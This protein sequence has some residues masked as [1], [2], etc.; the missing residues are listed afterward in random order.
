MTARWWY[1][2]VVLLLLLRVHCQWVDDVLALAQLPAVNEPMILDTLRRR[3]S[4]GEIYTSVGE[5]LLSINPFK[6]LPIY[7][8]TAMDAY[9]TRGASSLP[10]HIFLIADHAYRGLIFDGIDQSIVISGESGSGKTEA[11]KLALSY[12]A[13]VA[14]SSTSVEQRV[15]QANP[16]LEAYGNA[17]TIRNNNSSRFGK[18]VE[19]SLDS[20][21]RVSSAVNHN[22]L[23]EKSR[24]VVRAPSPR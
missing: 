2:L 24:V 4:A 8:P 14:G 18:L 16:I 12:I 10:P 17:K 21:A 20:K 3:F 13:H 11:T 1:T 7:T 23:L 22:Y 6:P 19:V 9:A 5:I 15:L